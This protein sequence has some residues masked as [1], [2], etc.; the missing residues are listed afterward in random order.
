[1]TIG[2]INTNSGMH[3]RICTPK[4]GWHFQSVII[5]ARVGTW[6]GLVDEIT[7]WLN[8]SPE[9]RR[10]GCRGTLTRTYSNTLLTVVV[11]ESCIDVRDKIRG[12]V[13]RYDA[14]VESCGFLV[15]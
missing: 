15:C 1:M 6:F 10:G 11:L 5:K 12:L 3:K 8:N 7:K 13:L 9:A 2:H 14:E 4:T